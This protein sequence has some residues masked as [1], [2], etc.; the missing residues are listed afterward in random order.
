M[1]ACGPRVGS[2]SAGDGHHWSDP[3][4]PGTL[5]CGCGF[6]IGKGPVASIRK[7]GLESRG[8]FHGHKMVTRRISTDP[9]RPGTSDCA[10]QKECERTRSCWTGHYSPDASCRVRDSRSE[11]I[12]GATTCRF[13]RDGGALPHPHIVQ[14]QPVARRS[15]Q[16]CGKVLDSARDQIDVDSALIAYKLQNTT[17]S[18][19]PGDSAPMGERRDALHGNGL[20]RKSADRRT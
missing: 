12:F 2:M 4:R 6:P 20:A 8:S 11:V 18:R 15:R 16:R 13:V 17:Q 14:Y 9:T 1:I 7:P 5:C 10:L 19:T 3:A